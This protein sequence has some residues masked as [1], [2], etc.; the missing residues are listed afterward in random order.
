MNYHKIQNK[1]LSGM[2]VFIFSTAKQ[3]IQYYGEHRKNDTGTN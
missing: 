1:I 2:L 3:Q